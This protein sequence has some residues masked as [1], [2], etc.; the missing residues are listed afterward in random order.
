MYRKTSVKAP[1]TFFGGRVFFTSS[2]LTLPQHYKT[3][4]NKRYDA[5]EHGLRRAVFEKVHTEEERKK[6]KE[7]EEMEGMSCD[8]RPFSHLN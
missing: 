4:F 5:T 6:E 1:L 2:F 8:I 3:E 7:R